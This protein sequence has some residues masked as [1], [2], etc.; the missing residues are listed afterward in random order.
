[1]TMPTNT[2][3]NDTKETTNTQ[4]DFFDTIQ[5]LDERI[6]TDVGAQDAF[7]LANHVLYL[8]CFDRGELAVQNP[9]CAMA[10]TFS[11]EEHPG[12]AAL[13][14]LAMLDAMIANPDAVTKMLQRV[15]D[16]LYREVFEGAAVTN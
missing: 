10:H 8:T 4:P 3:E 12:L 1:M 2:Q 11:N 13:G 7:S 16:N 9:A 5:R 6:R 14:S 15:R